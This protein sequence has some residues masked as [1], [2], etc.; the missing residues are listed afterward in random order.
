M[1]FLGGEPPFTE[2]CFMG[3]F[4]GR[5][6]EERFGAKG[7]ATYEVEDGEEAEAATDGD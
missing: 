5:K 4:G 1:D 3:D 7:L 6:G 2:D